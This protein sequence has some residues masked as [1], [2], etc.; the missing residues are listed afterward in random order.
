M[1]DPAQAA[2]LI[3]RAVGELGRLDF[4]IANAAVTVEQPITEMPRR[5]SIR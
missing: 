4:L 1:R 3:D 2:G 5:R